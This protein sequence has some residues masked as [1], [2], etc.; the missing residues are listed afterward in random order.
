MVL[1]NIFYPVTMSFLQKMAWVYTVLF[2]LVFIVTNVP[3]F[4]DA[5]GR[6]F[7]LFKIDPID[8]LVHLL[9]AIVGGIA[10]WCSAMWS[11][12]FLA[13]SGILYGL[14]AVVGLIASQGLLDTS[15][16]TQGFGA[17]DFSLINIL[18]NL[19]HIMIAVLALY[20]V[21]VM[22]HKYDTEPILFS[23]RK[24]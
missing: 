23:P 17:L 1:L 19:P 15:I 13:A 3:A 5:E 10:A 14:D 12:W 9:T 16:F 20:I 7:G 21:F 6:N 2:F 4:N 18:I 8:N 24:F 22:S 11:K